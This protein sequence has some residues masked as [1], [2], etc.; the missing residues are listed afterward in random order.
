MEKS[1]VEFLALDPPSRTCRDLNTCYRSRL[2][3][4]TKA[5]SANSQFATK[6]MVAISYLDDS[7]I[8]NNK[9]RFL[10][11]KQKCDSILIDVITDDEIFDDEVSDDD[12]FW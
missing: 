10:F 8:F 1:F 12:F 6:S 4:K 11:K 7:I 3:E 2:I 5:R 9:G